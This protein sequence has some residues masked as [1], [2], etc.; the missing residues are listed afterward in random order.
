M[1]SRREFLQFGAVAASTLVATNA[2]LSSRS[3]AQQKLSQDDLLK[4]NSKGQVTLLHFTD[5]H[6]QLKP[7]Y[8]RPPSI[9]LGVGDYAGLP[10][11]LVGE[12]FL[13][14]FGLTPKTPLAYAHTMVD[15]VDLARTYGKLGGLDRTATLVKAI[16]ADRGD[17]KVLFL[18]GGDTWQGSYTSLK[19]DGSDMVAPSG[20]GAARCMVQAMKG[21]C[22]SS[23]SRR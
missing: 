16:R 10:P 1:F 14:R 20:E 17:D 6:A 7:V 3:L 18:D 4:F 23:R 8:F 13:K 11:H 15:Y 9:N 2:G 5:V 21:S 22:A 19:T 12:D